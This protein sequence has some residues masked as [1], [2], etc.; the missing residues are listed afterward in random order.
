[1]I[2]ED[3]LEAFGEDI[4]V[5]TNVETV[6]FTDEVGNIREVELL[7]KVYTYD[8]NVIMVSREIPSLTFTE[9]EAGLD[10]FDPVP[11]L[12]YDNANSRNILKGYVQQEGI[13]FTAYFVRSRY[14]LTVD[15]NMENTDP[16]TADYRVGQHVT[17]A[18]PERNGYTFAGW[19]WKIFD[20]EQDGYVNW[21]GAPAFTEGDEEVSFTMPEGKVKMTAVWEEADVDQTV[22]HFFQNHNGSYDKE[23]TL[24]MISE[25]GTEAVL[26]LD[27]SQTACL[28][29]SN[30]G[31][32]YESGGVRLYYVSAK[33]EGSVYTVKQ[34]DLAGSSY[35]F[36][37]LQGK[38][39]P[40]ADDA[41]SV[42]HYSF[43]Y[44]LYQYENDIIRLEADDDYTNRYGM[45]LEYYYDLESFEIE[46]EPLVLD[47][48]GTLSLLG[49]GDYFYGKEAVLRASLSAGYTFEGWYKT[50]DLPSDVTYETLPADKCISKDTTISV[51]VTESESYTAVMKACDVDSPDITITGDSS[52]RYNSPGEHVVTASAEFGEDADASSFVSGYQWYLNGEPI[53]GATGP[54]CKLPSDLSAGNYEI[55]CE[56][57][58]KRKDNGM[59]IKAV[60]DAF[61]LTVEK[62]QLSLYTKALSHTATYDAKEDHSITLEVTPPE[63]DIYEIYYSTSENLTEENYEQG[64][65]AMALFRNT[66]PEGLTEEN[67]EE[68]TKTNPVFRDVKVDEDGNV[69]SYTV[70]YYVRSLNNNY[71]G[72]SGSRTVTIN[73]VPLTLSPGTDI[74][75]KVYDGKATVEGSA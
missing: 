6:D 7:E 54:N 29:Y 1:Y 19:N 38:E 69:E 75:S 67:Y 49:N 43:S 11:G 22:F 60:S 46:T 12:R 21:T 39:I 32:S 72:C 64:L 45:V 53:E 62:D 61:A 73:P 40:V 13:D 35:E 65:S 24:A 74:Y 48:T 71:E 34:E 31:L 66:V 30:G 2:T 70:Y 52:Y 51:R 68:G 20:A 10:L 14:T 18:S 4:S 3:D 44:A 27:G 41:L 9:L 26:S 28:V 42:P 36:T 58:A 8:G 57:T 59:T 15:K 47:G 25:E 5:S 55:T 63:E 16:E 37:A 17:V 23:A 56:V 33:K 50:A